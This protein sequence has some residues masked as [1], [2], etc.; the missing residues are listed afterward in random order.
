E[1]GWHA[2]AFFQS[3]KLIVDRFSDAVTPPSILLRNLDGTVRVWLVDNRI[4]PGHP[5]APYLDRH[6]APTFG[7]LKAE[8]GAT[9]HYRLYRPTAPGRRPVIV[10]LYGG[11]SVQLVNRAWSPPW[12]QAALAKGYAI[13]SLDNRG[14]ARRG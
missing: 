14:T 2:A 7:V 4:T 5:Y 8:D 10:H 9:L 13:F 1:P 11:P 6:V 12:Y 3:A